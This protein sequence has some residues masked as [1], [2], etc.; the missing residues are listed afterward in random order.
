M[1]LSLI[2][3]YLG[4]RCVNLFYL[5][6]PRFVRLFYLPNDQGG[7]TEGGYGCSCWEGGSRPRL[8]GRG[9][10]EGAVSEGAPA[11]PGSSRE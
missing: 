4:L 3:V 7:G 11:A 5:R 8:L 1:C 2:I 6:R 9:S 10:R